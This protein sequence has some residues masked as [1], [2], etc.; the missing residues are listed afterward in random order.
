MATLPGSGV[1]QTCPAESSPSSAAGEDLY[2]EQIMSSSSAIY[3]VG[4]AVI[5]TGLALGAHYLQ[6]PTHW[7]VVGVIVLAGMGL[8]GL[9][10]SRQG[11]K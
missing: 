5:I 1:R 10:K 8:T 6:V 7:I 2:T 4:Y 9:A 3:L 11:R